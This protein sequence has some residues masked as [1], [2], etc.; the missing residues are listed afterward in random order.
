MNLGRIIGYAG[1]PSFAMKVKPGATTYTFWMKLT[2]ARPKNGRP[3]QN[4]IPSKQ[5][6]FVE[7]FPSRAFRGGKG[8]FAANLGLLRN[9]SLRKFPAFGSATT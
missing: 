8:N 5:D 3:L 7:A 9:L 4:P 2:A 1:Q 6:G